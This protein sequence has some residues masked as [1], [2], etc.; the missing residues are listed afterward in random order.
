MATS[1]STQT[2]GYRVPMV[3][4][5]ILYSRNQKYWLS[6]SLAV[7]PQ[8]NCTKILVEFKF[9]GGISGRFIKEL[10]RLSLEVLEQN[11]EFANLQELKLA[12]C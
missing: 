11:Y 4:N 9:D 6:L 7:W 10:C 2:V 5:E 12:V 1:F 3:G 8:T